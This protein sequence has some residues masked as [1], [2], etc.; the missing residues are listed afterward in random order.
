ML[1]GLLVCHGWVLIQ[2]GR[3]DTHQPATGL[4]AAVTLGGLPL[5]TPPPQPLLLRLKPPDRARV[6]AALAALV[7]LGFALVLLAWWGARFTRRYLKRPWPGRQRGPAAN[8]SEFDWAGKPLYE[9][10]DDDGDPDVG[11]PR[12]G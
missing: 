12:D 9:A 8:I 5:Q 11:E 7:I 6:L 10:Q 2:A 3:G 4:S 1:L